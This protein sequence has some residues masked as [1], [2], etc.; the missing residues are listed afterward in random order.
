MLNDDV[1]AWPYWSVHLG[2]QGFAP[3]GTVMCC[4]GTSVAVVKSHCLHLSLRIAATQPWS[5]QGFPASFFSSAVVPDQLGIQP[6]NHS[7]PSA[8]RDCHP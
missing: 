3:F 5:R 2:A 7:L 6:P 1:V 4:A 8:E